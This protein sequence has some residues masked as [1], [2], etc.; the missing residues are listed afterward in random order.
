MD[1]ISM[2]VT[3]LEF[4][5]LAVEFKC[6]GDVWKWFSSCK[7]KNSNKASKVLNDIRY[8]EVH[9]FYYESKMQKF[10]NQYKDLCSEVIYR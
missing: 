10:V 2:V 4:G 5:R 1:K 6:D 3:E 9:T 7:K 8:K